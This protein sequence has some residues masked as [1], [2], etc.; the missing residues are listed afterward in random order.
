MPNKIENEYILLYKLIFD[1]KTFTKLDKLP[2]N[3]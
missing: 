3:I 1:M 2:Q